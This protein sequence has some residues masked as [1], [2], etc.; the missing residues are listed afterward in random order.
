MDCI[1]LSL[2]VVIVI[3]YSSM[4]IVLLLLFV[5]HLLKFNVVFSTIPTYKSVVLLTTDTTKPTKR[6]RS[7]VYVTKR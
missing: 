7:T 1:K 4:V 6:S 2:C 3:V 5:L